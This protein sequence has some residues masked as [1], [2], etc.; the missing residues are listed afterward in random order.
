LGVS[1][2]SSA[3]S[4]SVGVNP[5]FDSTLSP[6]VRPNT[7]QTRRPAPKASL[8]LGGRLVYDLLEV[9]GLVFG[10]EGWRGGGGGLM[11]G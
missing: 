10:F 6:N 2:S 3:L 9:G 5:N 8:V 7:P 4:A 11:M 1:F